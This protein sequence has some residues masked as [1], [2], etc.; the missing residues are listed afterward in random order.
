MTKTKGNFSFANIQYYDNSSERSPTK[1]TN[2]IL[3]RIDDIKESLDAQIQQRNFFNNLVDK[4]EVKIQN[5][6]KLLNI[7]H[8]KYRIGEQ[9]VEK[10]S[11]QHKID[12]INDSINSFGPEMV[13]LQKMLDLIMK[14]INKAKYLEATSES[15]VNSSEMNSESKKSEMNSESKKSDAQQYDLIDFNDPFKE[16]ILYG[17]SGQKPY[18]K[19]S[20]AAEFETEKSDSK[21]ASDRKMNVPATSNTKNKYQD[22]KLTRKDFS[23][24]MKNHELQDD[25]T[26]EFETDKSESNISYSKK[27]DSR[28]SDSKKASDRKINAPVRS[29][30]KNKYQDQ[31][32]ARKDYSNLVKNPD[33]QDDEKNVKDH[34]KIKQLLE[35]RKSILDSNNFDILNK[36]M[37][38]VY[39][40]LQNILEKEKDE[41]I[42][43]EKKMMNHRETEDSQKNSQNYNTFNQSE[44]YNT[45]EK[46][47]K[48]DIESEKEVDLQK[49]DETNRLLN[50][51]NAYQKDASKFMNNNQ[52]KSLEPIEN[53]NDIEISKPRVESLKNHHSKNLTD[54]SGDYF[55]SYKHKGKQSNDSSNRF[56]SPQHRGKYIICKD[57]SSPYNN[58]KRNHLIEKDRVK[59]LI[60]SDKKDKSIKSEDSIQYY[61]NLQSKKSTPSDE[62]YT[63]E[64]QLN[65]G[66]FTFRNEQDL[67]DSNDI[68]K[69]ESKASI[70]Y[71]DLIMHPGKVSIDM[72]PYIEDHLKLITERTEPNLTENEDAD[73]YEK[74]DVLINDV[75]EK[76]TSHKKL[77]LKINNSLKILE[78]YQDRYNLE[79]QKSNKYEQ[80]ANQ[81]STSNREIKNLESNIDKFNTEDLLKSPNI[82]QDF[83]E[84]EIAELKESIEQNK[85]DIFKNEP[86]VEAWSKK[87]SSGNDSRPN[88]NS[89]PST[90]SQPKK[91]DTNIRS[92]IDTKSSKK[93]DRDNSQK[94]EG[95]TYKRSEKSIQ[96]QSESNAV[97]RSERSVTKISDKSITKKT[98]QSSV[99]KTDPSSVKKFDPSS[100]KLTDLSS[101]KKPY[102]SFTKK[103]DQFSTKKTD[104][105]STKKPDQSSTKKPDKSSTKKPD[106]S[107]SKKNDRS[108]SKPQLRSVS[109]K[110]DKS[111]TPN[112]IKKDN[113]PSQT[114]SS[115]NKPI[116][117]I[118]CSTPNILARDKTR[119][120]KNLNNKN[121]NK[122]NLQ[123]EKKL[124]SCKNQNDSPYDTLPDLKAYKKAMKSKLIKAYEKNKIEDDEKF[125][126]SDFKNNET[127]DL[128]T[129]SCVDYNQKQSE[130]TW[131]VE[132]DDK[133]IESQ[134]KTTKK[135]KQTERSRTPNTNRAKKMEIYK[136]VLESGEKKVSPPNKKIETHKKVSPSSKKRKD[137]A[138][139]GREN[140]LNRSFK[141]RS[142]TPK[143]YKKDSPTRS[144]KKDSPTRSYKK[145]SPKQEDPDNKENNYME[146]YNY[147]SP[148]LAN[149]ALIQSSIKDIKKSKK[150]E[151][152]RSIN[153]VRVN[154]THLLREKMAKSYLQQYEKRQS[155]SRD[156]LSRDRSKSPE[157][158][159][160]LK[161]FKTDEIPWIKRRPHGQAW[162]GN[163]ENQE[164]MESKQTLKRITHQTKSS[165][166]QDSNLAKKLDLDVPI[167]Y[168]EKSKKKVMINDEFNTQNKDQ[169]EKKKE[170]IKIISSKQISDFDQK[171]DKKKS[172]YIDSNVSSN[173]KLQKEIKR[174]ISAAKQGQ[175]DFVENQLKGHGDIASPN[176]RYKKK[177]ND[178]TYPKSSREIY[179]D[180]ARRPRLV[181]K[182][183]ANSQRTNPNSKA[184]YERSRSRPLD[185]CILCKR[186]LSETKKKPK[187][188]NNAKPRTK[189]LDNLPK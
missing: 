92:R 56:V 6:M 152:P 61:N 172:S 4:T 80:E 188:D 26:A 68:N 35:Y 41:K 148:M 17:A 183:S 138:E 142:V 108:L 166:N 58:Q 42:E 134:K 14:K 34:N 116:K 162:F 21:R 146:Q 52:Y 54:S 5:S 177:D 101:T 165:Q 74:S 130:N 18:K 39:G 33:L 115:Q 150:S 15:E 24:L 50:F 160:R 45:V 110:Q 175:S 63:T 89:R 20:I 112:K 8:Y 19:P 145:G 149:L 125:K 69:P 46:S 28:K 96:K 139:F 90:K 81:F 159:G 135:D 147:R 13:N 53:Y 143:S 12:K 128:K 77:M 180:F 170:P 97:N 94:N 185:K 64:D 179:K 109:R 107:V 59:D 91:I 189:S 127:K 126:P 141:K 23:N 174:E 120:K 184:I 102:Q 105:S 82:L 106:R 153:D 181:Q 88:T 168:R 66:A 31:N 30:T 118:M 60:E 27:S 73:I 132:L 86:V 114:I 178:K 11:Y 121:L 186:S 9:E 157:K 93:S 78:E 10:K 140:S 67:H 29:K 99:K 22:Q 76:E 129:D 95:S 79:S 47:E 111:T 169:S 36:D 83:Y 51:N 144:Y 2:D 156:K 155:L 84:K 173:I 87:D 131:F 72:R 32:F 38:Q 98:R 65:P 25:E 182:P 124:K 40:I 119:D 158:N 55:D 57:V 122:D 3:T 48:Y 123:K 187:K 161:S 113:L 43:F 1:R 136:K 16:R 7:Q 70:E 44:T 171:I 37:D 117:P 176:P 71:R 49:P 167:Y 104:Q 133:K 75:I 151:T 103:P 85:K 137:I 62:A 100:A 154:R 164:N 163:L